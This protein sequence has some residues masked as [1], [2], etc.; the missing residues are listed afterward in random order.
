MS[1]IP[2]WFFNQSAVIPYRIKAGEIEVLLISSRKRKRWVIPKGVIEP[3]MSPQE[4]AATEAWE[5]AGIIGQIW[6]HSIGAYEYQKWGGTCHVQVFLLKVKTVLEDWPE[7]I[8][9]SRQWLNI[10][11]AAS[12]VDE[13][14]LKQ[15]LLALPTLLP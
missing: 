15:M 9:R 5:E 1:Q 2:E 8:I 10:E 6:P 4:S 11:E 12:R 7:A 3:S 13:E 14:K